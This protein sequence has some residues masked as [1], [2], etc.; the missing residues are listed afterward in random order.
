MASLQPASGVLFDTR[1]DQYVTR[2]IS[3]VQILL[4]ELALRS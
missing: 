2:Q 4:R 1:L 3:A